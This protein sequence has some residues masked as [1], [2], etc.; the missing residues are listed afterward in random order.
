MKSKI[1]YIKHILLHNNLLNEIFLH[2]FEGKQPS[3]W[4]KQIKTYMQDLNINLHAI[5]QYNP[6]KIKKL[7]KSWDDSLWMKDM[8]D[9]STMSIYR[10]FKH[11]IRDEQDL[12][13]NTASSV[14][15][16][17]ARTGTLKLN[18]ERRH[19]D[20]HTICDLCK[21]N[22]TE[23]LHHFLM[24]CPAITGTRR[25]ILGLQ[26]AAQEDKDRTIA[27]FLLFGHITERMI[28]MNRDDLQKL[29]QHRS[30]ILH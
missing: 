11:T 22:L 5:E 20:G 19:T 28:Y 8:Q 27:E 30:K 18:W 12:Y 1:F 4:I 7:V 24:E 14:P 2:Q 25:N 9:K 17:R 13:D 16:F 29:W 10:Q 23:D 26:M 15:L 21:M 6:A 3:K